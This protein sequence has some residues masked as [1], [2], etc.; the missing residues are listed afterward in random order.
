[1]RWTGD[2]QTNSTWGQKHVL[3]IF[4]QRSVCQFWIALGTQPLN[5]FPDWTLTCWIAKKEKSSKR[6]LKTLPEWHW[7]VAVLTWGYLLDTAEHRLQMNI[8]FHKLPPSPATSFL[9]YH[10]LHNWAPGPLKERGFS[11]PL[12][13]GDSLTLCDT[14]FIVPRLYLASLPLRF[15]LQCLSHFACLL[16]VQNLQIP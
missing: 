14:E 1:M 8:P 12:H 4:E 7:A 13:F 2:K 5:S 3:K 9:G 10:H 11:L 15:F 6:P 16:P